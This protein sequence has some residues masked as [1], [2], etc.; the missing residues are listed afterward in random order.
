M[1]CENCR[2]SKAKATLEIED[3]KGGTRVIY[4]LCRGCAR[5]IKK[6]NKVINEQSIL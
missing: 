6:E 1:N 4:N 5:L 3:K 2:I